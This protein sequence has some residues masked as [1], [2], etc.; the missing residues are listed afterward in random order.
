MLEIEEELRDIDDE[1][2]GK[3]AERENREEHRSGADD[4]QEDEAGIHERDPFHLDGN[5]KHEPD[6]EVGV[7]ASEG[8][9]NARKQRGRR[10][11]RDDEGEKIAGFL[12]EEQVGDES[13]EDTPEYA[14]ED[15]KFG[16]EGS[17]SLLE[18]L[19][20]E[21]EEV[22]GDKGPETRKVSGFPCGVHSRGLP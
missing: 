8:E 14:A 13:A 1:K 17:P 16:L 19:A 9:K 21:K 11:G 3:G 20:D 4:A 6:L 2:R 7:E 12:N 18:P 10:I 15:V 5:H 22:N